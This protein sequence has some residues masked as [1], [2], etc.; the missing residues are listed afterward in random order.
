MFHIYSPWPYRYDKTIILQVVFMVNRNRL[1]MTW[2]DY[3]GQP[4]DS[5][6]SREHKTIMPVIAT[7]F[8]GWGSVPSI[9]GK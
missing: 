7:S 6:I 1:R 4:L 3:N 2:F 5:V 9:W 8:P